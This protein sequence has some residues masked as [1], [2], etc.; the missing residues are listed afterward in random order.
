MFALLLVF[1]CVTSVFSQSVV[2]PLNDSEF[3]TIIANTGR[4]F[5]SF[6]SD[7]PSV[8]QFRLQSKT[9]VDGLISNVRGSVA[10]NNAAVWGITLL[11]SDGNIICNVSNTINGDITSLTSPLI[12]GGNAIGSLIFAVS[13]YNQPV[14]ISNLYLN[15][16]AASDASIFLSPATP[17]VNKSYFSLSVDGNNFSKLNY[18][19]TFG[20]IGHASAAANSV[21][22]F[23]IAAV[24]EPSTILLS[25]VGGITLL[26]S[27]WKN[28][29]SK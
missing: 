4:T 22:I 7:A 20:S 12:S 13:A 21:I 6:L 25:G 24:P 15:G 23:G 8:N 9:N 27:R 14:S 28:S 3:N 16:I 5:A 2:T 29:R 17:D 10:W 26:V 19:V 1:L 18:D 11:Y